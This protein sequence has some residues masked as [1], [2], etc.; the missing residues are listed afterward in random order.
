VID[1]NDPLPLYHQ[2]KALL[3]EQIVDGVWQVG[4]Q[5]P[6]EQQLCTRYHISRTTVKEAL[7]QL[8][9]EGL[10]Y[11]IQGKGTFVSSPRWEPRPHKVISLSD[12]IRTRHQVPSTQLLEAGV[13][14][15]PPPVAR[16]LQLD[17][18]TAVVRIK[19]LRLADGEPFAIQTA[20][21][22]SAMCPNLASNVQQELSLYRL[23]AATY[24][25]VPKQAIEIYKPGLL[26][27]DAAQLLAAQVNSPCFMVERITIAEDGRP[28]EFV[29]STMRG[30]RS[31]IVLELNTP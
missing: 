28:F 2:I 14:P 18:G 6:T 21:I 15:S 24:R 10:L 16:A 3:R 23:L 4:D 5:I 29:R 13:L 31:E 9:A 8:V 12:E 17:P 30:D 1:H 19:R 27:E 25:I 22:P 20:F 26:D 11:R 7:N